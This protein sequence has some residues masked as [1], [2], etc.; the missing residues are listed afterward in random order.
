MVPA[1]DPVP[2]KPFSFGLI[3]VIVS[4]LA[5][6]AVVFATNG[7]R[8]YGYSL[9]IGVPFSMGIL[10][11]LLYRRG[12]VWKWAHA[13]SLVVYVLTLAA[14]WLILCLTDRK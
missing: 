2:P 7:F 5:A 6:M 8:H 3:C 10:L 12:R 4:T 11:A 9:F 1:P 14:I 13:L